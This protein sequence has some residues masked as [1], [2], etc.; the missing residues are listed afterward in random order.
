MPSCNSEKMKMWI[1]KKVV[2]DEDDR[3]RMT[4]PALIIKY[5]DYNDPELQACDRVDLPLQ[6]A[7]EEIITDE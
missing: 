7:T 1:A 3:K 4:K 6:N 5:R 2:T